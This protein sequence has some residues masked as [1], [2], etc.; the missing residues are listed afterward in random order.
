MVRCAVGVSDGRKVGLG[1]LVFA[2]S[3]LF[4][5]VTYRLTDEGRRTKCGLWCLQATL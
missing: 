2:L 5:M 3:S 1:L 4:A